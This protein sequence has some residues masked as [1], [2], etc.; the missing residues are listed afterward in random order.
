MGLELTT[1]HTVHLA[2]ADIG[3]N[4]VLEQ[5]IVL[6][7]LLLL[8]LLLLLLVAARSARRAVAVSL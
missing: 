3:W 8:L 7:S 5:A 1:T 4:S 6:L 2:H